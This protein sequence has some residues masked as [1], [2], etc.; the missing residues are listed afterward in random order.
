MDLDAGEGVPGA[1]ITVV[2]A[3]LTDPSHRLFYSANEGT[4]MDAGSF[5]FNFSDGT[6]TSSSESYIINVSPVGVPNF[7]EAAKATYGVEI[8]FDR[9]MADPT[10]KHSEFFIREDGIGVPALPVH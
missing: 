8:T 2:P 10:G 1:E 9:E 3:V 7:L 4:G 6:G 5:D